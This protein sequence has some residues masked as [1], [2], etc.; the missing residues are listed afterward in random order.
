VPTIHLQTSADLAEN[1]NIPDILERLVE[2]L[3]SIETVNPKAVK[4]YHT[5]RSVWTMGKGAEPGFAACEL[6][7]LGGR[8]E[9]L[10]IKMADAIFAALQTSFAQSAATG[11]VSLTLEVREMEPATYRK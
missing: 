6:A 4:A 8:P 11:E 3:S 2:T 10:K 5:I 1:T 7:I 9:E